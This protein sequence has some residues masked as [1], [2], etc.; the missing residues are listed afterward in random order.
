MMPNMDGYAVCQ[1]LKKKKNT[2]NTHVIFITAK[3]GMITYRLSRDDSM[4]DY[5]A[6]LH[7]CSQKGVK[8]ATMSRT[9]DPNQHSD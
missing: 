8:L 2:E 5:T 9:L 1:Q 6:W 4:H 3:N 7:L